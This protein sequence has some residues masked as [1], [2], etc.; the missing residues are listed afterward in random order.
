MRRRKVGKATVVVAVCAA[1]TAA[2]A[3]TLRWNAVSGTWDTN[4]ANTVWLNEANVPSGFVNGA[5][6][7]FGSGTTNVAITVAAG[8]VSPA[9]MTFNHATNTYTFTGGQILTGTLTKTGAGSI[10]FTS[11]NSFSGPSNL[12]GG[13]VETRVNRAL[14]P[15]DVTFTDITWKVTTNAQTTRDD[16]FVN[17]AVTFQTSQP[18]TFIDVI[19]GGADAA[20][21]FENTSGAANVIP[22]L[23]SEYM[24]QIRLKTGTLRAATNTGNLFDDTVVLTIDAGAVMDFNGNGEG[25]GGVQGAGRIIL[26]VATAAESFLNF[27][28]PGDRTFSGIIEGSGGDG[29]FQAGGGILTLS[30]QSTFTTQTVVENGSIV[31]TADVRP[32]QPGPL[33]RNSTTIGVGGPTLTPANATLLIGGAHDVARSVQTLANPAG[34]TVTL[35]ANADADAQFNGPVILGT[36]TKLTSASTGPRATRFT[37]VISSSGADAGIEK[38]GPGTVSLEAANTFAGLTIVSEGTLVLAAPQAVASSSGVVVNG[39]ILVLRADQNVKSLAVAKSSPGDQGVDLAGRTLR[40]IVGA[41]SNLAPA[42]AALNQALAAAESTDGIYDSTAVPGNLVGVTDLS[43]DHLLVKLTPAG[44]AD[45]NGAV[46][47]ADFQRLERSFGLSEA[48]WDMGDFNR[49]RVVD[50]ADFE[51]L[52]DNFGA[53]TLDSGA[54]LEAFAAAHV[55]E[56]TGFLCLAGLTICTSLTRRRRRMM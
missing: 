24:G 29:F 17:G 30:G 39:G 41:G 36:T 50:F 10:V 51:V 47:F 45:V 34:G 16:V 52:Y 28:S 1:A 7:V 31:I 48:T 33:G 46:N 27:N 26:N 15:G 6:A 55:P 18:L 32:D 54:A 3:Q 2:R 12:S 22:N 19:H 43:G 53:T 13:S 14:G 9:S 56:T 38:V 49:D 35:G 11:A 4:A 21:T 25:L 42:E 37:N 8:G 5:N 23:G 20:I 40:I 44:D